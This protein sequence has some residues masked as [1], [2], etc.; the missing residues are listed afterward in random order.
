M[1]LRVCRTSQ[2]KTVST[3]VVGRL[4]LYTLKV[5]LVDELDEPLVGLAYCFTDLEGKHHRGVTDA[6]GRL[7]IRDL[8]YA[9]NK[10]TLTTKVLLKEME[11]RRLRLDRKKSTVKQRAEKEQQ[12]YLY[13]V[14]GQLCDVE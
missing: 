8:P 13:A 6:E 1:A 12:P 3:V 10:L 2:N 11:Q 14:V 9:E 5:Q 7:E 4:S